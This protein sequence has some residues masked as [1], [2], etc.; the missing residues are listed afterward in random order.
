M[1]E[2]EEEVAVATGVANMVG[3]I[4]GKCT[5]GVIQSRDEAITNIQKIVKQILKKHGIS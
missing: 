2:I 5:D 1:R 4:Y 3:C